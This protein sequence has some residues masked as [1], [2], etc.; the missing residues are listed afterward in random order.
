MKQELTIEELVKNLE[1]SLSKKQEDWKKLKEDLE[2]RKLSDCEQIMK[3]ISVDEAGKIFPVIKKL[4]ER[5]KYGI[6]YSEID[7]TGGSRVQLDR[8]TELSRTDGNACDMLDS[9]ADAGYILNEYKDKNNYLIVHITP[10]DLE[11][12]K[13][14]M[15]NDRY[16]KF[17][18]VFKTLKTALGY[19]NKIQKPNYHAEIENL[20]EL[21]KIKGDVTGA[22]CLLADQGYKIKE[23]LGL[24]ENHVATIEYITRTILKESEINKLYLYKTLKPDIFREYFTS[25]SLEKKKYLLGKIFESEYQNEDVIKW[26]D[27]T[28]P[29]LM[30]EVSFKD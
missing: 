3:M 30:R 18:N 8:I 26:L 13:R 12:F 11:L 7:I 2:K 17:S 5:F 25:V 16:K 24:T 23:E 29:D 10:K 27:K 20:I 6:M 22:I 19:N 1:N 28:Y 14:L 9:L 21:T 15:K 4:E